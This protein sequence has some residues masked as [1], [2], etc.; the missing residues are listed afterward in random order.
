MS[1]LKK[2]YP[3]L[4]LALLICNGLCAQLASLT[5]MPADTSVAPS[6]AKYIIGNIFITGNKKTRD[7]I[8]LREIPVRTGDAYSLSDLVK[9]FEDARRQLM[10]TTLFHSVLVAAKGFRGNVIDIDVSVKERWYLFP[11]PYF[12]PVDRNL[13]QWLVE[14]KASL[15]RV[16]YGAKLLYN[17]ATGNN[18]KLRL[19]LVSGYTKQLSLGYDRLYIDKAMK[20]GMRFNFAMGKNRELK[21]QYH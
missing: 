20:W 21:L 17:N 16:N 14:Q 15:S 6:A 5:D 11:L 1:K 13:N 12:K 19:W 2:Y 4:I 9:K 18:D 3:A 7:P 10:N 8:I